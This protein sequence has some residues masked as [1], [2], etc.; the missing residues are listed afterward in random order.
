MY[1]FYKAQCIRYSCD[2]MSSIPILMTY[3]VSIFLVQY[4]GPM[5]I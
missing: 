5:Q 2:V 3:A 4:N 1:V